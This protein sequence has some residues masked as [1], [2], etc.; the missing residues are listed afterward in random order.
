MGWRYQ[1][2]MLLEMG[3][4]VIAPDCLGYGR[5]V[6]CIALTYGTIGELI[7]KGR[8]QRPL[9]ILPQELR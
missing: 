9:A 7:D 6:C 3:L 1:I 2:P 5:T 8:P 4:R